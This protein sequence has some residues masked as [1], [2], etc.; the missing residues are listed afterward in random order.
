MSPTANPMKQARISRPKTPNVYYLLVCVGLIGLLSASTAQRR[1]FASRRL[2]RRSIGSI[3][4][5]SDWFRRCLLMKERAMPSM[6][7]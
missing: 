2:A 1:R 3:L 4:W 7:P 6:M 5:L